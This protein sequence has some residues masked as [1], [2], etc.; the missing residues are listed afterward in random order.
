M[1][2]LGE[3]GHKG[4]IN[5]HVRINETRENEFASGVNGFSAR[6]RIQ[7]LADSGDGL[8]FNIEY[9]PWFVSRK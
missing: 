6:R 3:S 2:V 7:I 9:L 4:Q 1:R 8:T 5:M